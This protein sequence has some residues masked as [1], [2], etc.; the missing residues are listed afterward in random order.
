MPSTTRPA[1]PCAPSSS[2]RRRRVLWLCVPFFSILWLVACV[3]FLCCC[4][5][6]Y[7]PFFFR[8]IDVRSPCTPFSSLAPLPL[9]THRF[10]CSP[11]ALLSPFTR[12]RVGSLL[13]CPFLCPCSVALAALQVHMLALAFPSSIP[14]AILSVLCFFPF[15]CPCSVPRTVLRA[16]CLSFFLSFFLPCLRFLFALLCLL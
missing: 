3:C 1:S 2:S 12:P 13:S 11:L 15:L 7:R 16:R 9:S 8:F 6:I 5:Q 10:A 4:H 14:Q